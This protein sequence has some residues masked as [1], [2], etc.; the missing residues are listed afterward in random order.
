MLDISGKF[1]GTIINLEDITDRKETELAL[2]ESE[3]R[4]RQLF[5]HMSSGVAVYEAVEEGNDFIIKDIN[6][7]GERTSV[8]KIQ[9]C[10]GKSVLD[11][12]PAI[13][14]MGL[15]E[16]FKRVWETGESEHHPISNYQDEHPSSWY[17]NYIYRLPSGE[18]VAVFDNVTDRKKAEDALQKTTQELKEN[19]KELERANRQILKQ[20]KAVI[21]EER[22]KVLLQMAG[23]TAHELNQPLM[24]LLGNIE[25]L[26]FEKN[27]P[28]K[29]SRRITKIE[30]AGKRIT[31]IV[32]KILTIQHYEVKS[33]VDNPAILSL[34]QPIHVLSVE[35]SDEDFYK[36]KDSLARYSPIRLTRSRD[37]EDTFKILDTDQADLIFLDYL[38]PSGTGLEFLQKIQKKG[39]ETP[40]VFVTGQGD[41]MVASQAIKSGAYDY[42]PKANVNNKTLM[43]VIQN[44]LEKFRLKNEVKLAMEKMA[45]LSS[46]DELTGLYNRRY[47]LEIF[48]RETASTQR[49]KTD[50]V[51]CMMDLDRFKRI[52][53]RYGH[54][55]GDAVLKKVSQLLRD[56][57]RKSDI[58]CRY[59]GEE[60]VVI[61]PNTGTEHAKVFCERFRKA[62]ESL[63]IPH[64]GTNMQ[65]T[66]S[67]GLAQYDVSSDKSS[68]DLLEKADTALYAAKKAGRNKVVA[69]D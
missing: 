6:Q 57:V 65:I 52:N 16:V 33:H 2:R 67:I 21:E 60:F 63:S 18:I 37:I 54:P 43:R 41:E 44:T 34:D 22:L 24:A 25:L 40:V 29:V 7:A 51:L 11:M 8:E 10:V 55:A 66:I 30:E 26:G 64:N 23:A 62:T 58:P 13:R 14:E 27:N 19:I 35:D 69:V 32:K 36:I 4:F 50:L 28:E 45:E 46:R 3:H 61:L 1:N 9:K 5:D 68:I 48:E 53:D 59:G 42:L 17:E 20:Q 56:S 15:L 47:F 49:Y 38:L 39:I 12:F 31:N